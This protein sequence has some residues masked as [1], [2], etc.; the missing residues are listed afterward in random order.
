LESYKHYLTTPLYYVNSNPHIGHTYTT[1]VVDVMKKYYELFGERTYF[2]TGTDEHGE[3]ILKAAQASNTDINIFVDN[4]SNKFKSMWDSLDINYDDFIRTTELRHKKIVQYILNVLY[5]K[6]DIYFA[7]YEGS[8]CLACERF[9]N[10]S[11]LIDGLCKDHKT[12]PKI[13]AEE[14]YF[15][16]LNKY[17]KLL[18]EKI[19]NNSEIIKPNKFRNEVIEY[20]KSD[21]IEGDLCISRPKSRVAW[22]IDLPFDNK[23]V[24]YV[25]FDALINYISAIAYPSSS[26]FN[27]MW[28]VAEHFI[29][30][31][32]LRTHTVYW[33]TMLLALDLPLYKSLN[34]HGY[35]NIEGSKMSK[36]IGNVVDPELFKNT[37]GIENLRYF[38]LKD[39]HWGEDADFTI[40]RFKTRYNA[41]LAN[42]FGNLISR[43]LSMVN[44]YFS[45]YEQIAI[46][47][48][49]KS[50]HS[51]KLSLDKV[52]LSYKE[53][54]KVYNFHKTLALMWSLFNDA[55]KYVASSAPW[56]LYKN[57]DFK[58]LLE[59]L[60]P[61][62]EVLRICSSLL[63][64]VMPKTS[65]AILEELDSLSLFKEG[66]NSF[67]R[68]GS[69]AFIK[70]KYTKL[71]FFE[72]ILD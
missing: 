13:V 63:Y 15:F 48:N 50:E 7:T 41:D 1:I 18:K 46:A 21:F 30:K 35:W 26:N 36:S 12:E 49:L 60:S 9:L 69:L 33:G 31:D 27:A 42:N 23:Y 44:K 72:R 67:T 56:D 4:I 70:T 65:L 17:S 64:P 10:S 16:K 24:A 58:T 47:S 20:L 29:A 68:W 37:Y 2:L 43:T 34:V 5:E 61:L 71:K 51:L 62:I 6:E 19:E 3:K 32:I 14:N 55:N 40:E 59:V 38:F 11:D 66:F 22:G 39:M 8:Y 28:N 45:D 25:W 54:F 52:L 57:K 53:D